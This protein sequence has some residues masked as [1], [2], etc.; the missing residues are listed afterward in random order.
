MHKPGSSPTELSA[1]LYQECSEVLRQR[2]AP[3]PVRTRGFS[4]TIAEPVVW[5]SILLT[6]HFLCVVHALHERNVFRRLADRWHARRDRKVMRPSPD[7]L[8]DETS[9]ALIELE[10]D[11]HKTVIKPLES[12]IEAARAAVHQVL[13]GYAGARQLPP[14]VASQ[15]VRRVAETL[16]EHSRKDT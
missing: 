4:T 11:L 5:E 16:Q 2:A 12:Q 7:P 13:A 15:F 10:N 1:R 14:E 6:V 9:K 8:V 3:Q